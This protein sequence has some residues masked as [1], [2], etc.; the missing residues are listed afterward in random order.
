MRISDWSSDVCSSDLG[1]DAY[2]LCLQIGSGDLKAMRSIAILRAGR[3]TRAQNVVTQIVDALRA[4]VERHG[5]KQLTSANERARVEARRHR[6]RVL[7]FDIL[8]RSDRRS[9]ER[10]VGKAC[11]STCRYRGWPVK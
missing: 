11:V 4:I 6:Q 10:R 7:E 2:I 5:R 9:E 1:R 8:L 3:V